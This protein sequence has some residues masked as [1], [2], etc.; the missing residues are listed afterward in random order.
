MWTQTLQAQGASV[1]T[2]VKA[3]AS[4]FQPL[5]P[6]VIAAVREPEQSKTTQAPCRGNGLQDKVEVLIDLVDFSLLCFKHSRHRSPIRGL[7][8]H[9]GGPDTST[10]RKTCARAR[11][12]RS[13]SLKIKGFNHGVGNMWLRTFVRA[14]TPW[15]QL[16]RR[17]GKAV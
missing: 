11:R 9:C 10:G 7:Q 13:E 14:D 12:V 6:D 3:L 8:L 5:A 15:L 16:K 2:K 17:L 1:L 4:A